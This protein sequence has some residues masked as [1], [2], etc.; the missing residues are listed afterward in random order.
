MVVKLKCTIDANM[1]HKIVRDSAGCIYIIH[2]DKSDSIVTCR[3]IVM[4]SR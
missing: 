4:E 3:N 2:R 1:I